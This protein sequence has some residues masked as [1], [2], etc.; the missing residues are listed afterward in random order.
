MKAFAGDFDGDEITMHVIHDSKSQ[1]EAQGLMAVGDNMVKDGKLII[2]FVQH[3]A[4]GVYKLTSKLEKHYQYQDVFNLL[5]KGNNIL[6]ASEIMQRWPG[7]SEYINGQQLFQMILTNYDGKSFVTGSQLNHLFFLKMQ[8][9]HHSFTWISLLSFMTRI[10]EHVCFMEGVSITLKDYITEMPPDVV[11]K[12]NDATQ[13]ANTLCETD[14]L[15]E[16]EIITCLSRAR[17]VLVKSVIDKLNSRKYP[18]GLL[19]IINSGAKGTALHI[20]Q[21]AIMVGLQVNGVTNERNTLAISHAFETMIQKYGFIKDSFFK[22]LTARDFYYH[23]QSTRHSLIGQ[24]LSTSDS[25]FTCFF[26]NVFNKFL[27]RIFISPFME[28]FRRSTYIL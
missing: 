12:S 3:S 20:G 11:T 8:E 2:G 25:G 1:A 16:Q 4:I 6:I 22:G 24:S 18:C 17:D 26:L 21:V 10:L 23:L 19:D 28:I 9:T 15:A 5:S 7:N 14:N 13:L 27:F